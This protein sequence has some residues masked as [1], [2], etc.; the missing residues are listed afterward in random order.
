MKN[1]LHYSSIYFG[2]VFAFG[3]A[4]GAIRVLL[5]VPYLGEEN[6]ELLEVPFMIFVCYLSARYVVT[7]AGDRSTA[8]QMVVV[9]ILALLYLLAVEFSAVLW[10]RELS[11][12]EYLNSKYS[13][14]GIAYVVSLVLY[15]TFPY[16]VYRSK[17]EV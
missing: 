13:V 7:L 11:V 2:I 14:A 15:T 16:V 9:G 4:L 17:N 6:S 10:L 12:A 5:L 1:I 8:P 3:F